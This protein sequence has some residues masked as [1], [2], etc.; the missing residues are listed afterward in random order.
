M[1][2][3]INHVCMRK[4]PETFQSKGSGEL[5]GGRTR[6][7]AGE[8]RLREGRGAPSHNLALGISAIGELPC[9]LDHTP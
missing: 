3:L 9:I 1:K 4:L 6:G 7:G 8:G 2:L 5:P